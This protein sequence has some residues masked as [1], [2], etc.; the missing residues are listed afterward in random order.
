MS[1]LDHILS[2]DP[3]EPIEEVETPEPE[4]QP[5]EEPA[6]EAAATEEQAPKVSEQEEPQESPRDKELAGVKAALAETRRE[7]REMKRRPTEQKPAP[8]IFED[9]KG[10]STHMEGL[11]Q[12][13]RIETKL[14]VSRALV[15]KEHGKDKINE[16]LDYFDENPDLS[17]EL[18][19]APLP[20]QAAIDLMERKRLESEIGSDPAG[21]KARLKAEIMAEVKAELVAEQARDVPGVPSMASEPN[22]GTRTAAPAWSGPASLDE[23]LGGS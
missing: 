13:A 11:V 1:D 10:Y 19:N 16:V 2:D 9:P 7:L 18:L 3:I 14:E 4:A 23:I 22:L 8:D 17:A 20:F 15:E 12:Q 21:Y 5:T 6:A